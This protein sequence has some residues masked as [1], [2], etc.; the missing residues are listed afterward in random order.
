MVN[1]IEETPAHTIKSFNYNAFHE[2]NFQNN[3]YLFKDSTNYE[4]KKYCLEQNTMQLFIIKQLDNFLLNVLNQETPFCNI[5]NQILTHYTINRVKE[6]LRM[7]I[8]L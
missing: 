8:N 3:A 4:S 2:I 6:K 1:S 7:Y 5:E